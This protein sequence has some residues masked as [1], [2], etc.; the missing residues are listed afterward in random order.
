MLGAAP[1]HLDFNPLDC[2]AL[3]YM[4]GFE[5]AYRGNHDE[6][7]AEALG[8]SSAMEG[9]LDIPGMK[10]LNYEPTMTIAGIVGFRAR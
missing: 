4:M 6:L 3:D 5:F 10:M 9:M 7:V 8:V 1:Y 2:E